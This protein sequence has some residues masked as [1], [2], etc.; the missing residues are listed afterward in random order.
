MYEY[1]VTCFNKNPVSY[2][3]V[4]IRILLMYV[5]TYVR[6]FY[7]N[8]LRKTRITGRITYMILYLQS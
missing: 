8:V 7:H 3:I 4:Y 5:G 2:Y 6:K 1:D